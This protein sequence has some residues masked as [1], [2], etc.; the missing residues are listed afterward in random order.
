MR[1]IHLRG[2]VTLITALCVT[3]LAV[4]SPVLAVEK[5]TSQA[6]VNINQAGSE[7]LVTLPGIGPAMA[8]RIIEHRTKNGP[9]KRVEDIMSVKGIGEK[10]FQKIRERLTL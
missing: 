10:K 3:A 8:K 1:W 2:W 4:Q 9:F 6:K 7:Q 5:K